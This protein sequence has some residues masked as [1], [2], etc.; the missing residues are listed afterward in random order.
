MRYGALAAT[1]S[2]PED[3]DVS[4]PFGGDELPHDGS[5]SAAAAMITVVFDFILGSFLKAHAVV[6]RNGA[7][8]GSAA[9]WRPEEG[10]GLSAMT[11]QELAA[12]AHHGRTAASQ[13]P[14]RGAFQVDDETP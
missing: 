10:L 12:Q 6:G 2:G 8:A 5:R 11:V 13:T 4:R 1:A 9:L 7:L 3:F 14:R